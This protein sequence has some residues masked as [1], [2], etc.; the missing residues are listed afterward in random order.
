MGIPPPTSMNGRNS[1]AAAS[2]G[3]GC[4]QKEVYLWAIQERVRLVRVRIAVV[5]KVA[6]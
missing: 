2:G 4:A 1:V 3:G 5:A 6:P